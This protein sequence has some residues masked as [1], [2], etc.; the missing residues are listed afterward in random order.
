[1]AGITLTIDLDSEVPA[2]Q[3]IAEQLRLL[4]A[5]QELKAGDR[6]PSVRQLGVLL[7]V[8]Q[9]TVA[10]AYRI[11]AAEG[12]VSLRHGAQAR[13][14]LENARERATP[15]PDDERK[16][17]D[18]LARMVLAGAKPK[19]IELMFRRAIRNFYPRNATSK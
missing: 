15:S 13:I 19:D 18:I 4:V 17:Q 3:Q 10:K 16:L 12:L 5:R 11:L 6:L 7:G 9:N 1:M 8:N 2:Y 14:R